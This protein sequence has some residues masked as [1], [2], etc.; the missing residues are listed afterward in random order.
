M[1]LARR[2]VAFEP[3]RFLASGDLT[4]SY[5]ELGDPFENLIR[6]CGFTNTHTTDLLFSLDGVTD[7]FRVPANGFKI[8]DLA[9]NEWLDQ[10]FFLPAGTQLWVKTTS[11][12]GVWVEA[13]YAAGGNE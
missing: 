12:T 7:H 1:N 2:K 3:L 13:I 5:Q 8:Y 11:G 4:G 6:I 10:G 9:T